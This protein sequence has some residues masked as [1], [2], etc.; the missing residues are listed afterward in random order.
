[1]AVVAWG[2]TTPLVQHAHSP[3]STAN[4]VDPCRLCTYN[5]QP[6]THASDRISRSLNFD[7]PWI[8]TF[9]LQ[10]RDVG[11]IATYHTGMM[12]STLCSVYGQGAWILCCF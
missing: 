3:A 4:R 11:T 12:D 9:C 8:K 6:T 10:L 7:D 2:L 5:P 1:M